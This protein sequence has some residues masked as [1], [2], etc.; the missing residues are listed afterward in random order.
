MIKTNDDSL[1]DLRLIVHS[2]PALQSHLFALTDAGT[3]LSEVMQ[4]AQFHGLALDEETLQQ[5]MLAGRMAWLMRNPPC[6]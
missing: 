1:M 2:D 3:F 4:L 5:A 6:I